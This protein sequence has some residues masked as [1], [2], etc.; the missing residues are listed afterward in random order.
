MMFLRSRRTMTAVA[1]AASLVL[2]ATAVPQ[3]PFSPVA[4]QAATAN[5]TQD[6]NLPLKCTLFAAGGPKNKIP[7][8]GR[9]FMEN[10]D[11]TGNFHVT[12]PGQV[13]VGEV[14]EASVSMDSLS[15][16]HSLLRQLG[17]SPSF[18]EGSAANKVRF[19]VKGDVDLVESN[20]PAT[21]KNG[22]L[23]VEKMMQPSKSGDTVTIAFAPLKLKFKAKKAGLV[24]I[25]T[26]EA[27]KTPDSHGG[28]R[29]NNMFH[30]EGIAGTV[31]GK[32]PGLR[33]T[34]LT[35]R[36]TPVSY[37]HLTLPTNREV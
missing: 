28:V 19:A 7:F 10:R 27:Y 13:E 17:G 11:F 33:V 18:E 35:D 22:V 5:K 26:P 15:A 4:A 24:E 1:A 30:G 14:F 21:L 34:C 8:V 2:T 12:M 3:S 6:T 37:T 20:P 16:S 32:T 23:T 25:Q 9:G 31:F 36:F 29:N